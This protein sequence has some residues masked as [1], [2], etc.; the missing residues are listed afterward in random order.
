MLA[1]LYVQCERGGDAV[2][3]A[4]ENTFVSGLLG[5]ALDEVAVLAHAFQQLDLAR[6]EDAVSDGP[7]HAP[8]IPALIVSLFI[9]CDFYL[10]TTRGFQVKCV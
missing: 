3:A 1:S 9:V 8:A 4:P 10:K 2:G 5:L 6:A 7:P